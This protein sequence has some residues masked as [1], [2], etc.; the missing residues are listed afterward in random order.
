[1]GNPELCVA[2]IAP[3]NWL[4]LE[5]QQDVIYGLTGILF[6]CL[7]EGK[8]RPSF[9]TRL[10]RNTAC[11]CRHIEQSD[12]QT[13]DS[14]ITLETR[15]RRNDTG[16]GLKLTSE[17]GKAL[18]LLQKHGL[19][20]KKRKAS[21]VESA[22]ESLLST[23]PL[24]VAEAPDM[25]DLMSCV[26]Y[27]L[28]RCVDGEGQIATGYARMSNRT[29]IA[30]G[31]RQHKVAV[32]DIRSLRSTAKKCIKVCSRICMCA[33]ACACVCPHARVFLCD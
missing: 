30:G 32:H 19:S 24:M 29:L 2:E 17:L 27:F 1:M 26:N 28:D 16:H 33:C 21:T 18:A 6:A 23:S 20:T 15:Q 3:A 7:C 11:R 9:P 8:R 25:M 10:C 22:L 31:Y 12:H 13:S 5:T 4:T 14:F